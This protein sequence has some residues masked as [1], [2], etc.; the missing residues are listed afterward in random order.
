MSKPDTISQ[1][2]WDR[3]S[4]DDKAFVIEHERRHKKQ[5]EKEARAYGFRADETLTGSS[6]DAAAFRNNRWMFG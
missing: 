1:T 2:M 6:A 5:R 4:D 3:L